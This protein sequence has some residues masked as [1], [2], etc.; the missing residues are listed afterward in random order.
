MEL[1]AGMSRRPTTIDRSRATQA[2]AQVLLRGL[3]ILKSLNRRAVSHVEEI[4]VETGLPKPTVVRMLGVLVEAGYAQR[5]P[6]RRGYRLDERVLTL[7]AGFRSDEMVVRVARPLLSAFTTV[8]K[9][10]VSI[11][12]LDVDAMRIRASTLEESPFATDGDRRRLARR[13]PMLAAALGRAYLG[14]CPAA[15]R[16]AIVALL[17]ASPRRYDQ[18]SRDDR[19]VADLIS[20]I[21]RVGYAVSAPASD[22]PAVGIALPVSSGERVLACISLRYLG[23][24]MTEAEVARRYL[25]HLRATA[26]AIAASVSGARPSTSG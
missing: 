9:W 4:A 13:V 12:T 25:P 18:P 3:S 17:K 26:Q 19:F 21:R 10:P 7:S 5:L 1:D 23:K 6:K 24:A 2:P 15:E 16:E 22:D 8:H 20:R 11:A 14:F